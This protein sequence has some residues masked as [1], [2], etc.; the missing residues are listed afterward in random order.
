MHLFNKFYQN[1]FSDS[2]VNKFFVI[3]YSKNWRQ[4]KSKNGI[5]RSKEDFYKEQEEGGL[6]VPGTRERRTVDNGDGRKE[7]Y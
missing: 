4:K 2:G 6:F 7:D 1:C 5:Y 3:F